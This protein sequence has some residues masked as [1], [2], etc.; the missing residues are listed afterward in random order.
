MSTNALPTRR[1]PS[2]EDCLEQARGA[3]LSS[4]QPGTRHSSMRRERHAPCCWYFGHSAG[5]VRDRGRANERESRSVSL[6][7]DVRRARRHQLLFREPGSVPGGALGHGRLLPAQQFLRRPSGADGGG[8]RPP[9]PQSRALTNAY[10]TRCP[11][12]VDWPLLWICLTSRASSRQV[13]SAV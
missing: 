1:S 6:V 4:L 12:V 9:Q 10:F 3:V 5:P 13:S 11:V 7:R 2:R 8:W